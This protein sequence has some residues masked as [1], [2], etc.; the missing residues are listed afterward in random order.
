M[1]VKPEKAKVVGVFVWKPRYYRL[2]GAWVLIKHSASLSSGSGSQPRGG[3]L[4]TASTATVVNAGAGVTYAWS[5]ASGGT[6]I[7]IGNA[8]SASCTLSSSSTAGAIDVNYSGVLQ[9]VT[10]DPTNG[11]LTTTPTT[12]VTHTHTGGA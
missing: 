2:S 6:G 10:T 11:S 3:T 4:V 5:W 12:S 1:V 7:A 9:C 8:T